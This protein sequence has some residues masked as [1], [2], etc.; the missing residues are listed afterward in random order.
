M[1]YDRYGRDYGRRGYRGD[2]GYRDEERDYGRGHPRDHGR[3]GVEYRT[4]Y[5]R[6]PRRGRPE[7][8]DYDDRGFFDRAGD[9]L[10]SWFGDDEAE[11]RRRYDEYMDRRFDAERMN[12]RYFP[13]P[14]TYD[15]PDAPRTN[16]GGFGTEMGY[17]M[18]PTGADQR[19]YSP[20]DRHAES[21]E[22][23]RN[24][25]IAEY[26]RDYEEFRHEN[27]RRFDT[28]FGQWREKRYRQRLA[29]GTVKEHQE[30]VGSDG[31]H[32]GTVDYV[33][34]DRIVLTK[35]DKDSGGHHHS[36]PSRWVEEVDDKVHLT[37]TADEAHREWR[38]IEKRQALF[39]GQRGP[40]VLN[41]SFS[42]TYDE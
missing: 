6:P 7:E 25:Q 36:I 35:T 10:R 26:D 4:D 8:Y 27:Q 29:V 22:A 17:G 21:Y 38:D 12:R 32:V 39:E 18:L 34:G 3:G 16:Y 19:S 42:G 2:Y 40:H 1:A 37:M 5:G 15:R 24:R 14:Y 9:E 23:W 28:E 20:R 41:R 13:T 30:V 31:E 33:R 11:R